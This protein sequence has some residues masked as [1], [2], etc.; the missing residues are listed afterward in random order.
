MPGILI[1]EIK[2]KEQLYISLKD[3]YEVVPN[4]KKGGILDLYIIEVRDERGKLV[5]RFKPFKKLA[6]EVNECYENQYLPCIKF[7]DGNV[8]TF[9]LGKNY[10]ISILVTRYNNKVLFPF[11]IRK[12]GFDSDLE[13]ILEKFSKIEI[14]LL[15]LITENPSL[16]E[17]LSYLFDSY[18]RL[19]END[20]EGART[21]LRKAIN[22]VL[23]QKFAE[24]II[25]VEEAEDFPKNFKKFLSS[26][27]EFIQTGGAHIGPAPRTTTELILE[28][29]AN[30]IE[31]LAKSLENNVIKIKEE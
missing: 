26:L 13:R 10:K 22:E 28:I 11:E 1:A 2:F 18:S 17:A 20:I 23:K 3:L 9:N 25:P 29:T 16:N 14:R 19:E 8:F 24:K 21:S 12:L 5:K 6:L 30:I 15:T 27:S 7:S 31:Y 4:V